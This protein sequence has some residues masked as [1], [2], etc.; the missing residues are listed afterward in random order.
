M[1]SELIDI[2]PDALFE[3]RRCGDCCKGYGG[4]YVTRQDIEA[5]SRH[6]GTD[7]RKFETEYCRLSG[8]K[9]VLAQRSD[10]YCIFWDKRCQTPYV[11]AMAF[12]EK[13]SGGFKKLADHG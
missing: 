7:P 1:P 2:D 12:C 9:P 10:G 4:T 6:I 11:P 3:C 8:Q 13:S 5:I